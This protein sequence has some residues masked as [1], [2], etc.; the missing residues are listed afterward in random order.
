MMSEFFPEV[1]SNIVQRA[2]RDGMRFEEPT[3]AVENVLDVLSGLGI[4]DT[5]AQQFVRCSHEE[6]YDFLESSDLDCSGE[7]EISSIIDD[8]YCPDCGRPINDINRKYH[9]R[10]IITRLNFRGITDYLEQALNEL[11]IVKAVDRISPSAFRVVLHKGNA[12]KVVFPDRSDVRT[13]SAGLFFAEPTFYVIGATNH[14]PTTTILEQHQYMMLADILSRPKAS[15][16]ERLEFASVPIEGQRYLGEV[17]AS[18]DAMIERYGDKAWQSF[19][20]EFVPSFLQHVSEH[21]ELAQKYLDKL[22][23][24]DSTVFGE[25]YVPVGGAGI[26]DFRRIKKFD[27]MNQFFEGNATGDAKCYLKSSLSMTDIK[28]INYHLDAD[29]SRSTRAVV[30]MASDNVVSTAWTA[31]LNLQHS[32]GKQKIL[33]IPKYLLLELITVLDAVHLLSE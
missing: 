3:D 15:L 16:Q 6:D 4:I 33:I 21:P 32:D 27:L 19:E 10:R 25:Y 12:L 13:L 1:D 30:L 22:R 9:F 20:Q 28:T 11:K 7:I 29:P 8:Y 31:V 26:A 5:E 17:E 24:L 18:F 2:L 23:R 14:R